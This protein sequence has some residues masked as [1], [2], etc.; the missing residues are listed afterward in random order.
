MLFEQSSIHSFTFSS[1]RSSLLNDLGAPPRLK[2]HISGESLLNDGS[3]FVFFTIFSSIFLTELGIPGLGEDIDVAR[4]F[5]IFFRMSL[6]GVAFGLAFGLGLVLILYC[7]NRRLNMEENV[8]QV[9]ATITVAYLTYYTADICETSG[10]IAT[11]FCGITTKAFGNPLIN[12]PALME[13]FWI[14]V[15]HLLNTL[16]FVL[17]GAVF[18]SIVASAGDAWNVQDWGYMILVYVLVNVIRLFLVGAFFP[19][20]SHIGLGSCWQEAV[21]LGYA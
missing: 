18:G 15:E 7:L 5:A 1:H 3:A 13:S 19:I 9:A 11:V 6:G 2:I 16:L 8:I 4:G 20:F 17:A 21:F 12:D 10:I 14:L